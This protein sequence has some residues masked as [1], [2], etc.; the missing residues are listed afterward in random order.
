MLW[1]LGSR[2]AFSR[3][4]GSSP[5][6][7]TSMPFMRSAISTQRPQQ[8]R[9]HH[10]L[11]RRQ[12]LGE[13]GYTSTLAIWIGL[14]TKMRYMNDRSPNDSPHTRFSM[15][16]PRRAVRRRAV[17]RFFPQ[18][19]RSGNEIEAGPDA[20]RGGVKDVWRGE[21][22]S[23]NIARPVATLE[24]LRRALITHRAKTV[25]LERRMRKA[26]VAVIFREAPAAVALELLL[27]RRA[28]HPKDPW[29]GHMAFPGGRVDK[30]DADALDAARRETLEEIGLDLNRQGRRVGELSHVPAMS[31]GRPMPLVILPYVF[32]LNGGS[33]LD[34]DEREVQEAVWVP[35]PFFQDP[36]NRGTLQRTYAGV[37]LTLACYRFEG[38]VIWG[39]TLKMIDELVSIL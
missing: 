39:L 15:R 20:R 13:S 31:H 12:S 18:G 14:R 21:G 34:L 11:M 5:Q 10:R 30:A 24:H 33:K 23:A 17:A 8:E 28:E 2:T 16:H 4:G 37:P 6:N 19:E 27:I 1:W 32:E 7:L 25:P 22:T 3:G 26:A 9:A 36:N 35:F 38:R 29:S